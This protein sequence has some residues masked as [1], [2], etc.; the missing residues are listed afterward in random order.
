MLSQGDVSVGDALTMW[1]IAVEQLAEARGPFQPWSKK[2][3]LGE[4]AKTAAQRAA[5]VVKG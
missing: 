3:K 2:G 5:V 4:V 1:R